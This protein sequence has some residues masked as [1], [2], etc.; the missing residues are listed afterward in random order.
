MFVYVESEAGVYIVGH[1]SPSGKFLAESDHGSKEA[2]A[3]RAHFL[4]GGQPQPKMPT[5]TKGA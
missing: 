2:A 5:E 1:Y 3:W 4:N